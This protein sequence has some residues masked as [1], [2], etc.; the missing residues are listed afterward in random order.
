MNKS[1]SFARIFV[2]FALV[3]S[4]LFSMFS[5]SQAASYTVTLKPLRTST[6]TSLTLT[7][8]EH[9]V[10]VKL[11]DGISG[12]SCKSKP[13]WVTV[14]KNSST[15]TVKVT[16]NNSTSD[17][18]GS[19]TFTKGTNTYELYIVQTPFVVKN[20]NG[21]VVSELS[22]GYAGDTKSIT[23]SQ[24]CTISGAVPSWLKMTKATSG[25]KYTITASKNDN[26]S[27]RSWTFT[28]TYTTTDNGYNKIQRTL[29]IKQQGNIV[30]AAR[31]QIGAKNGNTYTDWYYGTGNYR[32]TAWCACFASYCANIAGLNDGIHMTKSDTCYVLMEDFFQK[33]SGKWL[34]YSNTTIPQLGSLVFFD[35]K[36]DYDGSNKRTKPGVA[37]HVGIVSG[38]NKDS[39][40]NIKGIYVVEGNRTNNNSKGDWEIYY[41]LSTAELRK[42]HHYIL[43]YGK[44]Y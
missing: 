20:S 7:P 36:R 10:T 32:G 12:S 37:D 23:V 26:G 13:S 6:R 39:S 44:V 21:S 16:P 42:E 3:F 29:T 24:V 41:D 4:M 25:N 17:H 18:K 33:K 35:W 31:G 38:V 30:A 19:V 28:F 40:G 34:S 43:G 8:H 5:I 27:P 9:T 22:F 1:R 14:T 11:S 2:C 15:Y